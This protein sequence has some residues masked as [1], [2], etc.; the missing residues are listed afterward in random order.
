MKNSLYLM[1]IFSLFSNIIYSMASTELER[2]SVENVNLDDQSERNLL[3]YAWREALTDGYWPENATVTL[4]FFHK[5][6]KDE[7]EARFYGRYTGWIVVEGEKRWHPLCKPRS[8]FISAK[9]LKDI[10]VRVPEN[11]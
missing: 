11:Q 6:K 8:A 7:Y 10:D 2:T 3:A 1:V 9:T 4:V 5:V